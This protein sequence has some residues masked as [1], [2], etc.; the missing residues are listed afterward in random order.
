M[1]P[2]RR[3]S[4]WSRSQRRPTLH[5][6][7]Q[8]SAELVVGLRKHSKNLLDFGKAVGLAAL[9]LPRPAGEPDALHGWLQAAEAAPIM[10]RRATEALANLSEMW[11]RAI[12]KKHGLVAKG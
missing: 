12:K 3:R 8:K 4:R 10:H 2:A 6:C 11:E 7:G 1:R 5:A 9:F